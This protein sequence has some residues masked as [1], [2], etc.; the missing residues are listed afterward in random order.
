MASVSILVTVMFTLPVTMFGTASLSAAEVGVLTPAA[1]EWQ[2]PPPRRRR[3]LHQP[4]PSAQQEA[5]R[6]RL[7]SQSP[8]NAIGVVDMAIASSGEAREGVLQCV[9]LQSNGRI[10][11]PA[12][13]RHVFAPHS[14]QYLPRLTASALPAIQ[15]VYAS[16][17]T[18]QLSRPEGEKR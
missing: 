12:A 2:V 6:W 1:A 4:T 8:K 9:Q 5:G 3:L 11:G 17:P 10:A 14:I 13:T 15:T 18:I 16:R 7:G